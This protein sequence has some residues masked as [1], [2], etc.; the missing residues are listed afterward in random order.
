MGST[1]KIYVDEKEI[2]S[3]RLTEVPE[4]FRK[5]MLEDIEDWAESLGKRALNELLYSHL[6][7][8]EE[9]GMYCANCDSWFEENKSCPECQRILREHYIYERNENLDM[10]LTCIGMITRIEITM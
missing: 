6:V 5:T 8:Y 9:K 2:Y 10:L 7:W 4:K 3:G 1:L